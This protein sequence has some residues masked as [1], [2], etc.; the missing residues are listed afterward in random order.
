M[1][2]LSN[3]LS[4]KYILD[5]FD[6]CISVDLYN[7]LDKQNKIEIFLYNPSW[8]L[9]NIK[10]IPKLSSKQLNDISVRK[11]KI[12]EQYITDFTK[13]S[14]RY[15]FWCNMIRYDSKYKEIF[16]KNIKYCTNKTEARH[17]I[18]EYPE[19]ITMLN[20]NIINN[21]KL[22]CKEWLATIKFVMDNDKDDT[23][24]DWKFSDNMIEIFKLD[25]MAEVI[26]G[27]STLSPQLRNAMKIV[28]D[29]T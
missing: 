11:P 8:V 10:I 7:K 23:F 14:T 16:L 12:I 5:K 19:L 21:S 28:F 25:I 24:K 13:L 2:K 9:T 4:I 20:E 26:K 18:Y 1:I 17:V 3:N 22:T 6:D 27:K 29:N 15:S